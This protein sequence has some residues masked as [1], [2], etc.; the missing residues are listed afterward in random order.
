[1]PHLERRAPGQP[2]GPAAATIA[3]QISCTV[4]GV[5]GVT[6]VHVANCADANRPYAANAR[7]AILEEIAL[8]TPQRAPLPGDRAE[9]SK[10]LAVAFA[11]SWTNGTHGDATQGQPSRQ[12]LVMAAAR[13]VQ[14]IERMDARE[15]MERGRNSPT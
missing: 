3:Y 13:L 7:A 12:A 14:G 6:L 10:N 5:D 4:C 11:Q 8:A 15:R 2:P 9:T 1:M